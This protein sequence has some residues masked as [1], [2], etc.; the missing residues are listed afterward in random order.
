MQKE[1]P[2]FGKRI[3]AGI[4]WQMSGSPC[5]VQAVAPQR[6][7]HTDYVLQELLG[8]SGDEVQKLRDAEVLT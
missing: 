7:Q 2:E 5:E 1:H 4:P 6:G 8:Y 3:H